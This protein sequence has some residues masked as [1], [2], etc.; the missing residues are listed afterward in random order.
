MA[1]ELSRLTR[2]GAVQLALDEFVSLGRTAFLQRYGFGKSRDYLVKDPRS[3][4]LCDSKAI[5]GAAFGYQHPQEGPLKPS[6]FSGGEAT[7]VPLLRGLGFDVVRIGEDWSEDEVRATIAAY[8]EMLRCEALQERYRKSDLNATLLARLRRRTKPALE[9]K[10]QNISAVLH[11]LGL[12]FVAGYK[13]LANVQLLLRK[14]VQRFVLEHQGLLSQVVDALQEVQPRGEERFSAIVVDPPKIEEVVQA[15]APR[16]Y[17][18]RKV[19][20]AARDEGNRRLGRAG[21]QWAIEYE[22]LRLNEAGQPQLVDALEWVSE[23]RGDGAGYDILSA[24]SPAKPRYIEVKTTNGP[25]AS[26]F[27]ISRNELDFSREAGDAFYLYRI[28]QF[29]QSPSLYMLRGDVA[30]HLNL[31]ALDYRA[32]FRR[33]IG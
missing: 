16:L 9:R 7:V 25:H 31:E 26:S 18:P 1:S 19:D 32:S 33:L 14:E 2:T 17:L 29:R 12:P 5:V 13:P 24:D 23:T 6:E 4:A 15:S 8:F 3:G 20:F 22:H 27:I 28:F 30:R 21:E 10:H 11:A